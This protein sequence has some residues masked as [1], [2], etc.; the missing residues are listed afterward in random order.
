M[1]MNKGTDRQEHEFDPRPVSDE[2]LREEFSREQVERWR[3]E[4]DQ[5][6]CEWFDI[7]DNQYGKD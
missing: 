5:A 3:R 7:M 2:Q 6:H 1:N 4:A